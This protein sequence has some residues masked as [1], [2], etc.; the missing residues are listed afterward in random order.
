MFYYAILLMKLFV[1]ISLNEFYYGKDVHSFHNKEHAE[2]I[3]WLKL[4]IAKVSEVH[5]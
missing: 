1:W 4:A 5:P 2:V 3:F